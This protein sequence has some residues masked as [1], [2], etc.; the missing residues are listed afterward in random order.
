MGFLDNLFKN[1][2]SKREAFPINL[3]NQ[4]IKDNGK[5]NVVLAIESFKQ[6]PSPPF[7]K[8]S[9]KGL[10]SNKIFYSKMF[11]GEITLTKEYLKIDNFSSM[12]TPEFD[13]EEDFELDYT[14]TI[15]MTT[16]SWTLE[17][18]DKNTDQTHT[19]NFDQFLYYGGK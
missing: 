11:N 18:Y 14:L 10:R 8:Y 9:Q 5:K 2:S 12:H 16:E 13:L 1:N 15:Y 7:V 4:I 17:Y 6:F 19:M 3:Y